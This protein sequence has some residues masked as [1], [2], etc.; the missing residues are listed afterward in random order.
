M[1]YCQS[2]EIREYPGKVKIKFYR[3]TVS[4]DLITEIW[5]P[6]LSANKLRPWYIRRN[7]V[8]RVYQGTS[9]VWESLNMEYWNNTT[10]NRAF[11]M[12]TI[13]SANPN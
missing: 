10:P 2:Y 9:N 13:H 7:K 1:E 11:M 8:T 4:S 6:L 3:T 5:R 12:P